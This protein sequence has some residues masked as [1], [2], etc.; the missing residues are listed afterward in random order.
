[1]RNATFAVESVRVEL[2]SGISQTGGTNGK[3]S[4][5]HHLYDSLLT[6]TSEGTSMNGFF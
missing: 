3:D 2:H 6:L 4:R 1:M 5:Q